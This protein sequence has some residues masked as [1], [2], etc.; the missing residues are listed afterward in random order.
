M[1]Y[2]ACCK[3]T[4]ITSLSYSNEVLCK[5]MFVPYKTSFYV[6]LW[7]G[8]TDEFATLF[9]RVFSGAD[10]VLNWSDMLIC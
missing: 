4:N 6:P 5:L 10:L 3:N 2:I 9:L 1:Y 7:L 8:V